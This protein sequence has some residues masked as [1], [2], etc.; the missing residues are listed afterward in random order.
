[1]SDLDS[2]DSGVARVNRLA[3]YA[4]LPLA[5]GRAE[6]AATVLDAWW[7]AANELSAKMSAA[8]HRMLA[9]VTV[10]THPADAAEE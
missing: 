8:P 4:A 5:Q 10:L 9:P 3:Q 2:D 7:P 6:A 1:M